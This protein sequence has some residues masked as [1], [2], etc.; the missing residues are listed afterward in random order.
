VFYHLGLHCQG[1]ELIIIQKLENRM[2]IYLQY[3]RDGLEIEIPF[4]RVTVLQPKFVPGLADE[5][6]EFERACRNPVT[7]PPL[8]DL[9]NPHDRIAVVTP[10]GTRAMP[11]DR[12]LPWLF[13]ELGHIPAENFTV[14]L[15]TGTHRPNTPKEITQIV[16]SAIARSFKVINHDAF[17]E[18]TLAETGF[19]NE[20]G[21]PLLMNKEY[22]QADKRILLGFIEPHFMAG[23]SGGYKAVFPGITDIASILDYHRAEIIGHPRSTWGIPENNPTQDRIRQSGSVLPV[24]FLIN[25]TLNEQRA[26]TGFFCGDVLKAHEQGCIF[27]KETAMSPVKAPFPL[28]ITT[29]SGYPLDQ[30]LYQSVKGMVAAAEIVT[31]GGQILLVAECSDGFPAHGNFARLVF[32]HASPQ[33]MLETVYQPGFRLLDQWQIQKLAQVQLKAQVSVYSQIEGNE[34]RRANLEPVVDLN[35]HL[36]DIRQ[37]FGDVPIAVLPEGPL[38]IPYIT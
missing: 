22:V 29:N 12:L 28:V 13:N 8:R 23:F 3:G 24:D 16:G 11:S 25:V 7:S 35:V 30:N 14:I 38:T 31:E 33:A 34:I 4:S 18:T 2:N 20:L 36:Q 27:A 10:D 19:K 9:I 37:N 1:E 32:E 5:S 21:T 6:V 26:I 15:G 17:D